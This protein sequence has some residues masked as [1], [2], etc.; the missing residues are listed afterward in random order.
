MR[1]PLSNMTAQDLVEHRAALGMAVGELGR[2][3][4]KGTSTISN[5]EAGRHRIPLQV[6]LDV[7]KLLEAK[8]EQVSLQVG[9]AAAQISLT[10][11]IIQ[12]NVLRQSSPKRLHTT[13]MRLLRKLREVEEKPIVFPAYRLSTRQYARYVSALKEWHVEIQRRLVLYTDPVRQRELSLEL[14]D[15]KVMASTAPRHRPY[16]VTLTNHEWAVLSRALRHAGMSDQYATSLR[17]VW[18]RNRG[19]GSYLG[20]DQAKQA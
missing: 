19:A 8:I 7:R 3:L 12:H 10:D 11:M 14:A 20:R 18:A 1:K 13:E 15:L 6:A 16:D 2:A 4:N 9:K 5:Y 17:L